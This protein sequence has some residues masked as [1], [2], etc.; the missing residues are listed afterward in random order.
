M[1][2][3]FALAAWLVAASPGAAHAASIIWSGAAGGVWSNGANWVGGVAPGTSD[4]ATFSSGSLACSITSAVTVAAISISVNVTITV[5][6]GVTVT[7]SGNFTQSSGTFN[8]NDGAIT[9]GG[10]F[11]LSGGT[12]KSTTG[13]LKVGGAFNMTAGTF[14]ANSGQV[15]LASATSQTFTTTSTTFNN[16]TINDGLLGYWKLDDGSSPAVDSSG[17]GNNL[18]WTGTPTSTSSAPS[19]MDFSDTK[20]MTFNGSHP[21]GLTKTVP[22]S[23]EVALPVTVAAWYKSTTSDLNGG[24]IVS[25]SDGY[26]IRVTS[27]GL[28]CVKYKGSSTWVTLSWVQSAPVTFKDGNWHHAACVLNTTGMTIYF[29]GASVASNTDTNALQYPSSGSSVLAIGTHG[30]GNTNYDFTGSIDE[31]RI[32]G[33]ALS[34]GQIAT[35]A[36]G[37]QLGSGAATQTMS[38][39]PAGWPIVNGDLIIAS[40]V[41]AA[42]STNF[43]V[44]GSWWNYGGFSGTGTVTFNGSGTNSIL[45][46]GQ[47]PGGITISGSG[48]W[49]V[50]DGSAIE[51]TLTGSYT[52]SAGT[53]TAPPGLWIVGGAFNKTAGTFNGNGG[54]VLLSSTTNQNFKVS[55]TTSFNDLIINDGLAGY[56]KLDD[57]S[58]RSVADSSGYGNSGSIPSTPTWPTTSLPTLTFKNTSGLTLNGSSQYVDIPTQ[59]TATNQPFTACSWVKFGAVSSLETMVSIS[60]ANVPAFT[61]YRDSGGKF[62]FDMRSSDSSG[63]TLYQVLATTS[64]TT[65]TWYH[66]CGVYDGSQIHVY[67]NGTEQ[68]TPVT[69]SSTWVPTG[70]TY[71]GANPWLGTMGDYLNG[72]LD[73]VR[74][75]SRAL[76]ATEVSA[77]A[78]GYQPG[79]AKA[80]Q[81]MTGSP[82]ISGDLVIASGTLSAGSNN[83][84]VGAD[85]WNYGGMFIG[86][87]TVTFN[88]TGTGNAIRSAGQDF[89]AV[90]VSG[91][92]NWTLGDR[93]SVAGGALAVSAGTLDASGYTVR[94]GSISTGGTFTT[95]GAT[96]IVDGASGSTLPALTAGALRVEDPS[97]SNL[98]A[99]WKLDNA[100]GTTFR[101]YSGNGNTGTMFPG[102][103]WV[104]SSLP[105]IGY[106]DPAALSLDGSSGY[107]T[108]GATN[109][110]ALNGTMT[111]SFWAYWPSV[112][113]TATTGQNMFVLTDGATYDQIGLWHDQ[114][115]AMWNN[116]GTNMLSASSTP[117]SGWHHIAYTFDGTTRKFY[118][119][120]GTPTTS[121]T[122]TYGGTASIVYFGTYNGTNELFNG[123]LDDVRIYNKALTATQIASLAAG[124]YPGTGGTATFTLGGA[125]T[126]DGALALDSGSLSTSTYALTAANSSSTLATVSAGTLTIGSGTVSLKGGAT[127]QS[128][129]T[130]T[131]ATS[132]GTLAMGSSTTL[133]ID[134]T[135]NASSTGATIKSAGAAGTYYTF[136]VGSTAS[137]TPTLNITGLAVKNTTGGMAIGATTAALPV[138]TK[139]N[140]IAFTSGTGSQLLSIKSASLY[141]S[142]TGCSFDSSTTKSVALAGNGTSDGETRVVFGGATCG[143]A[144]CGDSNKSD[145]DKLNAVGASTPDG[146][147][148]NPSTNGAVVEFI[149]GYQDDT[150]GDIVG[151]PTAA[152]DW[153]TFTYYSTYVAFHNASGGNS[154]VVYVRDEAGNPLYSW[155]VPTSGE[156]ITGTPQWTTV[157]SKHYVFVATSAGKVY[158]LL[159]TATTGNSAS[160]TLTLD[161]GSG[162][163]WTTNPFNCSC[164]ITTPLALDANNVYWGSTT[165]NKNFWTVGISNESNPTPVQLTP[166]VTSAALTIATVSSTTYAF[167]GVTNSLLKISTAGNTLSDTNSSTGMG[168]IKGR[169][170]VGYDKTGLQRVFAG[171]DLGNFWAIDPGTSFNTNGGAWKYP[172]GSANAING[173]P[174]YDHDTNTVQFGTN[175]GTIVVL[176]SGTS[177]YTLRN[178]A[179]PYTPPGGGSGDPITAAPLYYNGILVVGS[180]KGKLYFLDR[181]TGTG[182]SIVKQYY[183]GP[184]ESVS[185]IGY[186]PTFDR[187]M[188]TTA[189]SSTLDGRVY[190]FD[191]V[192]DPTSSSL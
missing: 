89:G 152:F 157:N 62:A 133:T 139:F 40:G 172:G 151:F 5:S 153:N 135:L 144:T 17:Y 58:G 125:V 9:I 122:A 180:T 183:F 71:L 128:T 96:V 69:V 80:V 164:T 21:D 191:S 83:L 60:G 76:T 149:R 43:T 30:N 66:T 42:G 52:Q 35:L 73:D 159:D 185:G 12:F 3:G 97:E 101:D 86:T 178:T 8:G 147:G 175:S 143:G 92:G 20:S 87:G 130:L 108:M 106:D 56:W 176:T 79:T 28:D 150:A 190:F 85:W 120:G 18:T 67:V 158:R 117:A 109:L 110:P 65:A 167:M 50:V 82:T 38:A 181:N 114:T 36:S 70:H 137:A 4:T 41:L 33:R 55:G 171:D 57:A 24:E 72:T 186:D 179:Y 49:T 132:G 48:S 169:V 161:T 14:N 127:F 134:G 94:A 53:F 44:G 63:A 98:V 77:L 54:Q 103:S 107:A 51:Q 111:I 23:V 192:S 100:Q 37:F 166:V 170:I 88:G 2:W 184:N 68:G 74:I 189:N 173:S 90:T 118:V 113:G 99:Y 105:S 13:L 78:S 116:G 146:V 59:V 168:T 16:L 156:T 1:R 188:V 104:T 142:S 155:T 145:D 154:D 123:K 46:A 29:D 10:S 61:L 131:M 148:D 19:G 39:S 91:S 32:Y 6:S 177:S 136:T 34:A 95:T 129:G 93:L 75:Y 45:T 7:T 182:V 187:Y 47:M 141:L 84:T 165:S 124:R 140:N 102:S 81:T 121:T 112:S 160:A 31:V 126:L 163:A 119:D 27:S 22:A 15:M 138:F 25:A 162:A 115:L 26:L 174:Y 64:P 11:N